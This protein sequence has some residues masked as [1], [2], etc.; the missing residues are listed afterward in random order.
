MPQRI[1]IDV[2]TARRFW[3]ALS[4]LAAAGGFAVRDVTAAPDAPAVVTNAQLSAIERRLEAL[5]RN[6]S[7][8]LRVTCANAG[9][10]VRDYALAGFDCAQL[11][12][13]PVSQAGTPAAA[14]STPPPP[15]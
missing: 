15:H 5:E 1:S 4:M 11:T 9:A 13:L 12:A 3:W 7:A 2:N 10:A 6:T 8:M 14:R